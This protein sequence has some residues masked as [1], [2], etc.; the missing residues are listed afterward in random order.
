MTDSTEKMLTT[1]HQALKDV[2][3]QQ[4]TLMRM[5]DTVDQKFG[6]IEF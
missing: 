3:T 4:A 2:M 5:Y 6:N 1:I